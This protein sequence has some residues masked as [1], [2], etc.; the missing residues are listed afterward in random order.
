MKQIL[1]I[2]EF[3]RA[4]LTSNDL[5]PIYVGLCGCD[6]DDV[7][8]NRWLLAYWCTYHAGVSSYIAEAPS[9]EGFWERLSLLAE[10]V[11]QAPP[12]GRWPRGRERRH[13]R[14]K[15]AAASLADLRHRYESAPED[16]ASFCA[17]DLPTTCAEVMKR[18]KLHTGFGPW[19]AFKIADMVERCMGGS[20]SFDRAEVFMFKDPVLAAQMAFKAHFDNTDALPDSDVAVRWAVPYLTE[21]FRDLQAPPGWDRAVGLQEVET[22]LCK[23]KSHV[24]GHYPLG[25]DIHEIRN[26]LIQWGPHSDLARQYLAAMPEEV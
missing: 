12:G 18:A 6:W 26:G 4:L 25:N 16:M 21:E 9:V 5:D 22:V 7:T 11:T 20:V 19:I 8:R 3:G 13:W 1:T 17:G 10:N 15:N 2:E 14:G 23:W 24:N